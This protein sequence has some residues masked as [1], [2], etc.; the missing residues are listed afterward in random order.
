MACDRP[1]SKKPLPDLSKAS[2]LN[3]QLS[4]QNINENIKDFPE[5]ADNY[6]KKAYVLFR[7]KE[8]EEAERNLLKALEIDRINTNYQ[9]LLARIYYDAG[10]YS[11]A[12]YQANKLVNEGIESESA[13][14]IL[15]KTYIVDKRFELALREI[16]RAILLNPGN[17]VSYVLKAKIGKLLDSIPMVIEAYKQSLSIDNNLKSYQELSRLY[18]EL[19]SVALAKDLIEK[20]IKFHANDFDLAMSLVDLADLEKDDSLAFATLAN[21]KKKFETRQMEVDLRATTLLLA[22]RKLDSAVS[23]LDPIIKRDSTNVEAFRLRALV[24]ERRNALY[25]ALKYLDEALKVDSTAQNVVQDRQRV[26]RKI[27]Y[28]QNLEKEL[29]ELKQF[30]RIEPRKIENKNSESGN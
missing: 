2:G 3:E 4:L 25:S 23:I 28:L 11:S 6:F 13:H 17:P 16:N 8:V 9:V 10:K 22:R 12:R 30:Q 27:T 5:D 20:S 26:R 18:L 24:E 21:L 7:L 1:Y 15:S 14:V 29:E 19:D